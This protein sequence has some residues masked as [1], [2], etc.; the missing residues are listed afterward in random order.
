[1]T[2]DIDQLC[3]NTIRTLS[4]DAIE[5]ANS[6]HPGT[7]M[8][9]APVAYTLWQRFLRF[10]PE[11]PIWPGRDRFV[12]SAGHASM[13]L[14]SLLHLASVKAVDPKYEV[15]GDP[16]RSR[17]TT[18]KRF[19]QLDSQGTRPPRV[20]LDLRGRDDHRPARPGRRHLGRHGDRLEVAARHLQQRRLRPLRLRHLRARRR[21][22]PDGGRLQRS[23]LAGRPPAP[24]Q[25]LLDLRQQPH[26][27]RRQDHL[28]YDDDVAARFMGYGWNVTRVG[29]ANDLGLLDRALEEFRA[30][31]RPPDPG[32][33]RQPHR[34]GLPAQAGHRR[35]PRR[36]ARRG[37]G[38][39]DQA[40]L[41]LARR[42]PVPRPR[43]ASA[44]TS[45]PGSASAA[46]RPTPP[47][48]AASRRY[49][50]VDR[51]LAAQIDAMQRRELPDG[52]DAAI[53]SFAADEAKG[54][55]TR[56]ASRRSRTR[57]PQ[58]LPWLLAGS[59]DLTDSTAVRLTFDGGRR[60][61]AR[62]LRR[63]PAPLRHPRARVGGDLQRPLADQAAPALVDLPHLLRLRPPGDPALLADGAAGRPRLHPRLD[64]R[65][66]RTARPTSRSSSSPACAPSPGL[67][68]IR[69]A[70]ANEVAE[71]WRV[72]IEPPPPAGRPD[73][74]PPGRAGARSHQV[75]AAEGTRRGGYVL[76]DPPGGR[77]RGDPDRHRREVAL[78]LAAHEELAAA[79]IRS[80]V[81]S[82]P[83]GSSSTARTRPTSTRCCRP[84]SAPASRSSRPRPSAGTA[85]SVRRVQWWACIPSVARR[86]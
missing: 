51:S 6:G 55:A 58:N 56:K 3:I 23:R 78:A 45:P 2:Q 72:A 32:H 18:S 20:P 48:C 19:R 15:V 34:L 43:R 57:S 47:G 1:M 12:L 60:L 46:P 65:S 35:R 9:M 80:R 31:V 69:P 75:R 84:G 30:R 77:P 64:R 7:P 74:H 66:A 67:D 49:S 71:A 17:S 36:A 41:R 14:Y 21:R 68:V 83:A 82:L 8:A 38:E 25:P 76:A 39:G 13:L 5:K 53:P 29:D 52:W 73:P 27:H 86:R 50:R 16:T 70:D 44:S 42:R 28:A 40:R 26:H 22:L 37:G 85:R 79:G 59:A 10:D 54:M 11:D 24:R 33:R 61:R 63:P 4:I 81:V 62:Q